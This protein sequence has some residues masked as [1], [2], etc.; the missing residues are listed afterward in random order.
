MKK[1]LLILL[2]LPL[3]FSTC[4]K[5]T[6]EPEEAKTYV[7]DDNFESYLEENG[8]GDGIINNNYVL[9]SQ[10]NAYNSPLLS[11]SGLEISDLTGIEEFINISWLQCSDNELTSLDVSSNTALKTLHCYDNNL[12]QLDVSQN[13]QLEVLHCYNNQI[14][15]LNL[16]NCHL[17]KTLW[18]H[19]NN[20]SLSSSDVYFNVLDNTLLHTLWVQNNNLDWL[21]LMHHSLLVDLNCRQN[22]LQSLNLMHCINLTDFS[23]QNNQ[24]TYLNIKNGNNHNM[25]SFLP[26]GN[27]G[28]TCIEVDNA[29][30]NWPLVQA[31]QYFSEDCP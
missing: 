20:L 26:D 30:W 15:S 19:N 10:L 21:N 17:L 2:C 9:T 12:T 8:M 6:E 24:L 14:Q 27:W 31:N 5:E 28:L 22:N 13:I 1:L 18:A 3:L 7:P 25:V 11:I 4:K 29:S 16:S 23:C